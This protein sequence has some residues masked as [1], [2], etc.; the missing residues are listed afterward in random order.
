MTVN[1]TGSARPSDWMQTRL[2]SGLL[3]QPGVVGLHAVECVEVDLDPVESP[4]FGEHLGLR[5]DDLGDEDAAH[6]FTHGSELTALNSRLW[7]HG[8]G[9]RVESVGT[10]ASCDR[11]RSPAVPR[12]TSGGVAA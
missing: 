10:L 9:G 2:P 8:E 1:K 3:E 11:V 7:T 12:V 6:D 4:G 5:L